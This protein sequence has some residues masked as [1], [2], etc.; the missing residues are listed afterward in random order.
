ME[1]FLEL[2]TRE[3]E[4]K[5]ELRE[6]AKGELMSR[7]NHQGMPLEMLD[8]SKPIARLEGAKKPRNVVRR[9]LYVAALLVLLIAC[10]ILLCLTQP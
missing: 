1:R 4:S 10:V 7:I 2:A 5:P 6:E 3:L 8:L 9:S